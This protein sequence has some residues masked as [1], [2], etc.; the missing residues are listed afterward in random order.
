MKI[1][2]IKKHLSPYSI[3]Q[4]RSTTINHAY[5]SALAEYEDFDWEKLSKAL[6]QLGQNLDEDLKC[7]YCDNPATTWDHLF[8]LVRNKKYA[9]YGHVI[10]NLVP[11]CSSCNSK[12]GN[13]NWR[14]YLKDKKEKIILIERHIDN[15]LPPKLNEESMTNLFPKEMEEFNETKEKIFELMKKADDIARTIRDKAKESRLRKQN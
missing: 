6:I 2:S 14:D 1:Q 11:S 15:Y 13:K 3:F 9:G 8:G 4:K 12:K 7:F 5:A 10:G